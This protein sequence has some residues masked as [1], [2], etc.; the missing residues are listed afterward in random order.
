MCKVVEEKGSHIRIQTPKGTNL[1]FKIEDG[2]LKKVAENSL[3]EPVPKKKSSENKKLDSKELVKKRL[4]NLNERLKKIEVFQVSEE[5]WKTLKEKVNQALRAEDTFH[6]NQSDWENLQQQL[7]RSQSEVSANPHFS[8]D[9]KEWL[10]LKQDVAGIQNQPSATPT[11]SHNEWAQ[12][13][14]DVQNIQKQSPTISQSEWAQLQQDVQN[15][16]S[17]PFQVSQK[18]WETLQQQLQENAKQIQLLEKR[19]AQSSGVVFSKKSESM[20]KIKGGSQKIAKASGRAA[21]SGGKYLIHHPKFL[22][23]L[24]AVIILWMWQPWN[25]I[26]QWYN[27]KPSNHS[28]NSNS[29]NNGHIVTHFKKGPKIIKK[30]D[31]HKSSSQNKHTLSARHQSLLEDTDYLSVRDKAYEKEFHTDNDPSVTAWISSISHLSD[32]EKKEQVKEMARSGQSNAGKNISTFT[33]GD[34]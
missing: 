15:I 20:E 6:I 3:P 4:S 33:T 32:N 12:L 29:N 22:F 27:Q 10:Q 30:T 24:M 5:D 17:P 19:L 1:N 25:S 13:Q 26:I 14:Q 2:A 31:G 28:S 11:I 18:E 8:I 7:Q 9:E 21:L 16:Q 23:S 34:K